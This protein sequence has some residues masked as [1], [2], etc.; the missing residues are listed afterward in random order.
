MNSIFT[1][2]TEKTMFVSFFFRE[3]EQTS[4]LGSQNNYL[5]LLLFFSILVFIQS[6]VLFQYFKIKRFISIYIDIDEWEI[7]IFRQSET[8]PT[9]EK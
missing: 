1:V 7:S 5:L 4:K 2:G 9:K 3:P 6:I 8:K